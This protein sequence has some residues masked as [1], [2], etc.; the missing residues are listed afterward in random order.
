MNTTLDYRID[1]D[2]FQYV[3]ITLPQNDAVRAEPGGWWVE[4]EITGDGLAD[5]NAFGLLPAALVVG[6]VVWPRR[7]ARE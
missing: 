4:G 6:R 5:S 1:G 3:Q 7:A 2:D